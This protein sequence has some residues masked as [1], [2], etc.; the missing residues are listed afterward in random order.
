MIITGKTSSGFDFAIDKD[1]LVSDFR[2]IR[3]LRLAQSSDET[4]Q[5][6]GCVDLISV[7]F[8]DERQ[9]E[10]FYKHI[11]DKHGDGSGRVPSVKVFEE[12]SEIIESAQQ[13]KDV[14]N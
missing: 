5:I 7:V 8:S 4:K 11:A 3:A 9:E 12:I 6:E 13:D 14:K 10:K 1:A 2:F